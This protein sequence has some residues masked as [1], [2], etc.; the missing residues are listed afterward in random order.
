MTALLS[1]AL[2]ALFS[3]PF[4]NANNPSIPTYEEPTTAAVSAIQNAF[5]YPAAASEI[6]A[7]TYTLSANDASFIVISDK[8]GNIV[9]TMQESNVAGKHTLI[10]DVE[11]LQKGAYTCQISTK[12]SVKTIHF[13]RK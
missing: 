8:D 12:N 3:N 1:I 4:A 13:N 7:L 9:D 5:A 11:K 2:V 6:V 10:Y